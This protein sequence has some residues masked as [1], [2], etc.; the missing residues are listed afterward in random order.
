L[1]RFLEKHP[2]QQVNATVLGGSAF[3]GLPIIDTTTP[4]MV[5]L[6]K[7]TKMPGTAQGVVYETVWTTDG[8]FNA[9]VN[10]RSSMSSYEPKLGLPSKSLETF[11][12]RVKKSMRRSGKSLDLILDR[13]Q[14]YFKKVE[15]APLNYQ[16]NPSVCT[17]LVYS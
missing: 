4:I 7:E 1:N 16:H 9:Y 3:V 13:T 6:K 12:E 2:P 15:V 11:L 14:L 10:G 5:K 8:N 17:C